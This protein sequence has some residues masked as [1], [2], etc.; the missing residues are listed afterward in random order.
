MLFNIMTIRNSEI[1]LNFIAAFVLKGSIFLLLNEVK[2]LRAL[3][4][5]QHIDF[6]VTAETSSKKNKKKMRKLIALRTATDFQN[7]LDRPHS[8]KM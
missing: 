1:H 7:I 5:L 4:I 2:K 3:L 6:P 8:I